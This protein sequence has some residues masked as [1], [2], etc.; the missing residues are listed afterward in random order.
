LGP[1]WEA[2]KISPSPGFD[3]RTVQLIASC[4][5]QIAQIAHMH[6]MHKVGFAQ[7]NTKI[8]SVARKGPH[9]PSNLS[10]VHAT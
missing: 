2:K 6:I 5:V 4:C 1:L 7:E 10:T 3:P 8:Y 9:A